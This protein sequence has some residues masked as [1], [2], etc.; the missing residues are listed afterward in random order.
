ME[1]GQT[2]HYPRYDQG[3]HFLPHLKSICSV[4]KTDEIISDGESRY[5]IWSDWLLT[6]HSRLFSGVPVFDLFCRKKKVFII[7]SFVLWCWKRKA[8]IFS[9]SLRECI[10][11]AFIGRLPVCC[12]HRQLNVIKC[13]FTKGAIYAAAAAWYHSRETWRYLV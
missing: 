3:P 12:I 8:G 5:M 2:A 6:V 10:Y 7:N 9:Q 11:W 13:T 1:P 4:S